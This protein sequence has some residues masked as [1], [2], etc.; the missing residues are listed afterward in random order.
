M[1]WLMGWMS[2]IKSNFGGASE[3]G[4][5]PEAAWVVSLSDEGVSCVRPNGVVEAIG[6]DDLKKVIIVTT[7]EGP[8]AADV[9]WLLLG[10]KSGCMIP[11]GATGE[12]QLIERL[13]TLPGFDN[14]A[15]IEAMSSTSNRKFVCWE[16]SGAT[17]G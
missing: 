2:W 14:E 3:A 16:K 8:F 6:W 7:D 4:T 12:D 1:G 10:E 17:A 11:L 5:D 9:M 15:M 13:Q